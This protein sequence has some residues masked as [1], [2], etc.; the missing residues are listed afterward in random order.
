MSFHPNPSRP[1]NRPRP[2]PHR[3]Q[4]R[5]AHR[6]APPNGNR[7]YYARISVES[8]D[9]RSIHDAPCLDLVLLILTQAGRNEIFSILTE[10]QRIDIFGMRP[11]VPAQFAGL[12]IPYLNHAVPAA[13]CD[14]ALVWAPSEIGQRVMLVLLLNESRSRAPQ[15][16]PRFHF[17]QPDIVGF[18]GKISR[19]IATLRA[20]SLITSRAATCGASLRL[21]AAAAVR[22]NRRYALYTMQ[23]A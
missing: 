4:I 1:Y 8:P 5:I 21:W 18:R 17:P 10:D 11:D 22:R 15:Q 16:A 7:D 9:L 2:P 20:S 12:R 19:A 13:G 3:S 14:Q 23:A 6:Q